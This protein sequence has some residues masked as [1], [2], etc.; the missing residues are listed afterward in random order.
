MPMPML[1]PMSMGESFRFLP[2]AGGSGPGSGPPPGT[3]GPAWPSAGTT[4]H[5]YIPIY[6]HTYLPIYIHTYIPTYM[7]TYIHTY[8]HVWMYV[9]LPSTLSSIPRPPLHP[10]SSFTARRSLGGWAHIDE[11][12]VAASRA[13]RPAG[14]FGQL[15]CV[16]ACLHVCICVRV[17]ISST[18]YLSV[19]IC[20]CIHGHSEPTSHTKHA[21]ITV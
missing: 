18:M 14:C 20:I 4:I 6:L 8:L 5:T 21:D 2:F 16:H 7:S 13:G 3:E 17:P 1:M 11:R 9:P 19:Y 15:A 12:L 10:S